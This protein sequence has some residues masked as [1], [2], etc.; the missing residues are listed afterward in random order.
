MAQHTEMK[1][2]KNGDILPTVQKEQKTKE[3]DYSFSG[4][5]IYIGPGSLKKG[6]RFNMGFR[7]GLPPEIK[8]LCKECPDIFALMVTPAELMVARKDVS[9]KGSRM[10]QA[11]NSADKYFRGGE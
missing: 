7:G 8:I 6:L 9:N 5:R 2:Q 4:T 3:Q 10:N 11:Y 1:K